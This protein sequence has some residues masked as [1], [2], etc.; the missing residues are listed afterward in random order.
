MN[1]VLE[2]RNKEC[3]VIL[4][5]FKELQKAYKN[6]TIDE[7]IEEFVEDVSENTLTVL[8]NELRSSI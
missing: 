8:A 5:Y 4:D 2:R 6:P 3:K 7:L 1:Q